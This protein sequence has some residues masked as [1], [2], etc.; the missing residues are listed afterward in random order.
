MRYEV[1]RLIVAGG[2]DRTITTDGY[3]ELDEIVAPFKTVVIITGG[4]GGVDRA[5]NLWAENRGHNTIQCNANWTLHGRS[6]GPIR[7]RFM[8]SIADSV[9]LFPGGKGTASMRREA[10][11]AGLTIYEM[12]GK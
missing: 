5:A 9:A 10:K 4:A 3:K 7:N 8:A 11:L 12:E 2:R 6:A 1:I